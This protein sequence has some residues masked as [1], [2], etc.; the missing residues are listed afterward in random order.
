MLQNSL[1]VLPCPHTRMCCKWTLR[2]KFPRQIYSHLNLLWLEECFRRGLKELV[3]Q[4]VN[5][6]QSLQLFRHTLKI[7]KIQLFAFLLITLGLCTALIMGIVDPQKYVTCCYNCLLYCL[8]KER[9]WLLP[10][11]LVLTMCKL[12][13]CLGWPWVT[14]GSWL[15]T[16]LSRF[17]LSLYRPP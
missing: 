12:M 15:L 11:Y 3:L 6:K 14:T 10:T 13:D 8:I 9:L 7:F 16:G 1:G 5:L 2:S 4:C 17:N